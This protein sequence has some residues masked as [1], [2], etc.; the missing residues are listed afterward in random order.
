MN[1][2]LFSVRAMLA[3]LIIFVAAPPAHACRASTPL[4]VE[5]IRQADLVFTGR[6]VRYELVSPGRPNS[7]DEYALLT[8]RVDTVLKGTASG[9]VQLYWWNSTFGVPK[10][11]EAAGP[12]LVAATSA[13]AKSLPLRGPSATVFASRRPDLPQIL[14]APCSSAFIL[15]D[16]PTAEENVRTILA[17]GTAP[18]FDY[19]KPYGYFKH[20]Q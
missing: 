5:D 6:L 19:W 3:P 15:P 20:S 11:M 16:S 18:P 4:V 8:V 17:G 14:Q 1:M 9:D 12:V 10:T 2:R 7:L 13:A